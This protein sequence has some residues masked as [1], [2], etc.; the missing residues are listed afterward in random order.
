MLRVGVKWGSI[1]QREQTY[2]YKMNKFWG[3]N[4]EHGENH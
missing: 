1:D 3:S 2:K 4:G